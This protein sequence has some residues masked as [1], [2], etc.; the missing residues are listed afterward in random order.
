MNEKARVIFSPI[1]MAGNHLSGWKPVVISRTKGT[2]WNDIL[3]VEKKKF[4]K[5]DQE[6]EIERRV[7]PQFVLYSNQS[8]WM[9]Q[10]I[11]GW[12]LDRL[13]RFLREKYPNR[14]FLMLLGN[15]APQKLMTTFIKPPQPKKL[16]AV[17][18]LKSHFGCGICMDSL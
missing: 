18:K 12:E 15:S 6:F 3:K 14:R 17:E 5:D 11:F 10:F 1:L 16:L 7:F 13:S 8:A 2:R 4:K 9:T